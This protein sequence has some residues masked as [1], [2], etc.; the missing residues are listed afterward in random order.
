MATAARS[1]TE[2]GY[3]GYNDDSPDSFYSVYGEVFE[4]IFEGEREGYVSEGKIDIE[5]MSN[6]HLS[7]VHLGDSTSDWEDVLAFYNVWEGFGS[8]L[9]FAWADVYHLNDIR[10]APNRR[11]RR[12]MED[13]N[14][15]KRKAAKRERVERSARWS[16]S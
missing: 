13:D 5:K 1:C 14:K 10:E 2:R 6:F 11:V 12:L 7:E 15:K 8:C 3:G 9:S 4:R 16:G